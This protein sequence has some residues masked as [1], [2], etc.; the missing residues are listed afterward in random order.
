MDIF[1]NF[2]EKSEISKENFQQFEEYYCNLLYQWNNLLPSVTK[3]I[4]K[5]VAEL[6]LAQILKK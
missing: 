3:K 4:N 2:Y 6:N 5:L 1:E